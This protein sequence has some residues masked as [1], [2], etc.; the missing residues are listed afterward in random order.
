[1]PGPSRAASRERL[2]GL[3]MR[4][5]VPCLPPPGR[6]G[7]AWRGVVAAS[8]PDSGANPTPREWGRGRWPEASG[9]VAVS[10]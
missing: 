8:S 5:R 2:A 6:R 9:L 1:M 3:E 10:Y 7:V 4:P